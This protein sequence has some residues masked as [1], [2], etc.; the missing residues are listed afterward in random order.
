M[1]VKKVKKAATPGAASALAVI[2]EQCRALASWQ[3]PGDDA[4][5]V[6]HMQGLGG[7]VCLWMDVLAPEVVPT[8]PGYEL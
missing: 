2:C 1:A 6:H 7:A 4:C 3:V 8:F 5:C